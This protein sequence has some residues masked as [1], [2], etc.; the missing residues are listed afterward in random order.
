MTPAVPASRRTGPTRSGETSDAIRDALVAELAARGIDRTSI[1]AVAGRAGVGKAAIYRRWPDKESMVLDVLGGYATAADLWT[2]TGSLD[3]DLR[4]F[5]ER[6]IEHLSEPTVARIVSDLLARIVRDNDFAGALQER[7][8]SVR[9]ERGIAM[10][11]RAVDRGELPADCDRELAADLV[12]APLYWRFVVTRGHVDV[13]YVD[14]LVAVV[15]AGIRASVP[16]P[17]R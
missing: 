2:D 1:D 6:C 17:P 15:G 9:R 3:G 12:L 10:I 14:R 16:G 11:D 4:A 8:G 13:G 5:C 7:V